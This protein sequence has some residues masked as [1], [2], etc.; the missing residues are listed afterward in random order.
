ME[1]SGL[2]WLMHECSMVSK[3]N[4]KMILAKRKIGFVKN[5]C[6]LSVIRLVIQFQGG[7][8][9]FI[10]DYLCEMAL[11]ILF[12]VNITVALNE[13]HS[14]FTHDNASFV[15]VKEN[16][17]AFLTFPI[18]IVKR[19]AAQWLFSSKKLSMPG[20]LQKHI[21]NYWILLAKGLWSLNPGQWGYRV[22]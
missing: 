15:I 8:F 11:C 7:V 1:Y 6:R 2:F 12:I 14:L 16:K 20:Y 13:P 5:A 21:L 3:R 9:L 19:P 18:D 22:W 10:N 4:I 17:N